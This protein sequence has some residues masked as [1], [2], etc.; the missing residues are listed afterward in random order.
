MSRV[1]TM[2]GQY[3]LSTEPISF[4]YPTLSESPAFSQALLSF[5]ALFMSNLCTCR[6]AISSSHRLYHS[7]SQLLNTRENQASFSLTPSP[8]PPLA[9]LTFPSLPFPSSLLPLPLPPP[10]PH[11][12]H[13][14]HLSYSPCNILTFPSLSIVMYVLYSGLVISLFDFTF[15]PLPLLLFPLSSLLCHSHPHSLFFSSSPFLFLDSTFPFPSS[16]FSYRL[17]CSLPPCPSSSLQGD[18]VTVTHKI[19]ANWYEGY[20]GNQKGVF[21]ITYIQLLKKGESRNVHCTSE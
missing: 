21:P 14:P 5:I 11:L 10:S 12:F 17:F 18:I 2:S 9:S 4:T 19:D 7:H 3:T 20:H 8:P 13:S 16:S 15:S 1:C 6:H